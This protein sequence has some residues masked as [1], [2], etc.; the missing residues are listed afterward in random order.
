[1]VTAARFF[2]G[3]GASSPEL[4]DCFFTDLKTANAVFKRTASDRFRELDEVCVRCFERAGSTIREV[5]DVG[6]SSGG[7]TVA[8]ADR[9]AEAGHPARVT[10]TDLSLDAH[11]VPV[12]P[13]VRTLVD[14]AGFPLQHDVL[15]V[16]VRPWLRRLDYATGMAVVRR[17]INRWWG[18]AARR[19]LAERDQAV[20]PVRLVS[21]RVLK[22]DRVTVERNDILA[23]TE[24]F[25]DRFDFVRIANV[26]NQ[27]YFTEAELRR[28]LA[29]AVSYLSGPGAW[30]LLVRSRGGR[31]VATLFQVSADGRRLQAVDRFGG[32]SEVEWLAFE[33]PIP[34]R[35]A[36]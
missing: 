33:A 27:G 29:N 35:W 12:M 14:E 1:M 22:H 2:S 11:L 5:L 34:E 31:H 8:L 17:V 7:A 26:L 16:A 25:R 20:A 21:P 23:P 3:A 4:E 24:R 28:A 18:G 13:G 9:L 15:G 32:G 10:G 30:L 6:V 36:S 19:R